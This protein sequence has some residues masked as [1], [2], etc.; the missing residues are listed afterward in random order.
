MT[1]TQITWHKPDNL[2]DA[3]TNVLIALNVDGI[4]TSCEGFRTPQP[5]AVTT[6]A[7]TP[8]S[9]CGHQASMLRRM[10]PFAAS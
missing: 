9:T 4:R 3:Q 5:D 1:T 2:P 10:S 8:L 6:I 7:S